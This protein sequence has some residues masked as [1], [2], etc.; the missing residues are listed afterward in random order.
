MNIK[1]IS[2]ENFQ[3]YSGEANKNRFDFD[4]GLNVIIGDNGAGKSKLFDAFY[5]VLDDK[6]YDTQQK[7]FV[8]T[9]I[10]GKN[11][12]SDKLKNN[13]K[14][15]E[16]IKAEVTLEVETDRF[17]YV[18]TRTYKI[19]K[20]EEEDG[21]NNKDNWIEPKNSELFIFREDIVARTPI[22]SD[23]EKNRIIE[24]ILPNEM[25]PY[26][27]YQGEAVNELIN[28]KDGQ[29]LTN[30]I[31]VLS[32][33]TRYDSYIEIANKAYEWSEK[34]YKKIYNK[35]VKENK[36][37][38]E[39]ENNI[40][41]YKK[42][43][44]KEEKE[45][46][47]VS[48][49]LKNAKE[50]YD[51]LLGIIEEARD[52]S[53]YKSQIE[54]KRENYKEKKNEL[55][56][57]KEQFNKKL[58][59]DYWILRNANQLINDY[60]EQLKE[61]EENR[62]KRIIEKEAENKLNN[63]LFSRLP[64]NVPEPLHVKR[65][66]EQERCLVCDREA[67]EGTEAYKKIEELLQAA[68]DDS[69]NQNGESKITRNN[70]Q[71]TFTSLY[72]NG[73]SFRKII[74]NIDEKIKQE[75]KK[76]EEYEEKLDNIEKEI[77]EIENKL[78]TFLADSGIKLDSSDDIVQ[79]FKTHEKTKGRKKT[80]LDTKERKIEDLKETIKK[81]EKEYRELG[82]GKVDD[83]YLIQ[84]EALEDF[85]EVS[86]ST[87]H[88]VFNSLIQDLESEANKHFKEMTKD[89]LAIRGEIILEEQPDKTYIPK[90]VDNNGIEFTSINDANIVLIKLSVIMAIISAKG[91][92]SELYPI[93]SDAP[94]SKFGELYTMGFYK[95]VSKVYT[96]S[97]IMTYDFAKNGDALESLNK[98]IKN[99]GSV[100]QV[101]PNITE[102]ERENRNELET[103]IIKLQ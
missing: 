53:K 59:T 1:S 32:D 5:W 37:K 4:K 3:C 46:E 61:Y 9:S 64:I 17:S 95:V 26:L 25:K 90:N 2:L 91:K 92:A 70:Y 89:N 42:Q 10:A 27:W 76:I 102:E 19:T 40:E 84:L 86:I 23:K 47:E 36:K 101:K 14:P 55:K 94:T 87:R 18:I 24:K 56:E 71:Q 21:I 68:K 13:A 82:S 8:R 79:E 60:E 63:K 15:G 83:K 72:N 50:Q 35:N 48:K 85:K 6:V 52:I 66:L 65:M 11:I 74:N 78:S 58:F 103:N 100:Y 20:K 38:R 44:E 31:N 30:A 7:E 62:Q 16:R 29:T 33:I 88:R 97:I 77:N 80:E 54:N 96:Q 45:K 49:E 41:Y 22:T 69:K 75:I 43:K 28:F 73:L 98:E 81:L 12:I 99:L 57:T 39:L 93:I 67:K 34:E 51:K